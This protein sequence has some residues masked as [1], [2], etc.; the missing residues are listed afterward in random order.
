MLEKALAH[1]K[2]TCRT[3]KGEM[4]PEFVRVWTKGNADLQYTAF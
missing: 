3:G 2:I 1:F 4:N